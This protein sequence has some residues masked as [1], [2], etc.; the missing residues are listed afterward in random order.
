[1]L[2]EELKHQEKLQKENNQHHSRHDALPI[3]I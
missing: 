1:M 3:N 2:R